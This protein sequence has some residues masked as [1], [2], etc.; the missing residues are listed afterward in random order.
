MAGV[1]ISRP[2]A[3]DWL[4]YPAPIIGREDEIIEIRM[5]L[6]DPACRLLTLVGTGGIGKTRLAI[7]IAAQTADK[8]VDGVYF[9]ALQPDD[10]VEFLM[11]AIAGVLGLTLS[12]GDIETQIIDHLSARK[13][14][15]VLDNLDHLIDGADVVISLLAGTSNLKLMVTSRQAL[16]LQ[17]EWRFPVSGLTYPEVIQDNYKTYSAIQLFADRARQGNPGF[18]LDENKD[19]VLLICQLTGGLPLALELAASWVQVLTCREIAGEIQR[20]VDFLATNQRDIPERHRSMQAVFDH[21]W[22]MLTEQERRVFKRL[23]IFRGGFQRQAAQAVA[24]ASL[25]TLSGL[26]NKSLLYHDDTNGRY[27]LQELLRQYAEE[28]LASSPDDL[29]S[30]R[31]SHAN[32]YADFLHQREADMIGSKQ[33]EATL[34]IAEEID[35]VRAAWAWMVESLSFEYIKRAA[36]TLSWYYEY[37]S[38]FRENARIFASA[39]HA[40]DATDPSPL[41]AS[42]LSDLLTWTGWAYIRLGEVDEAQRVLERSRELIE[43]YTLERSRGLASDPLAAL[44]LVAT[45]QGK[46]ED[47]EQ[48]GSQ[49]LTFALGSGNPGSLVLAYYVLTDVAIEQGQYKTANDLA[50]KAYAAAKEGSHRWFM[51][52]IHNQLG[53]TARALGDYETARQHFQA[54]HTIREAF[55]DPEGMAVAL[56]HLGQVAVLQGDFSGAAGLYQQGLNIYRE[57]GDRGGLITSLEGLGNVHCAQGNCHFAQDYFSEALQLA[58]DGQL[59]QFA[60]SVL[61][62]AGKLMIRFG[63]TK[64]G[65]DLLLAVAR[66]PASSKEVKMR[67]QQFL[68]EYTESIDVGALEAEEHADLSSLITTALVNLNMLAE[69][70]PAAPVPIADQ[71]L[72]DPLT[73]RELEVLALIANGL[74]NQQIADELIIARGTVKYYTSQI[75]SKLGVQS[76]TQAVAKARALKLL[77]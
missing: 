15:L 39:A 59:A 77:S 71:G 61:E 50:Q 3:G 6:A 30:T 44:S 22:E 5:L 33:Q 42:V 12:P 1:Q 53:R 29:E 73:A 75:Y 66:H 72:A 68:A 11:S 17:Q 58:A 47:A 10:D 19:D 18:S 37:Q 46:Y 9:V 69:H 56:N 48:L 54:S 40:I 43:T 7:E 41:Q 23:A 63:H 62:G 8:F 74:S 65:R 26:V 76:R 60:A 35:N 4:H 51:A 67:A 70:T 38:R 13:T 16:N 2:L 36:E 27:Y 14:L 49:A 64:P 20:S 31:D 24:G 25:L 32:Y 34:E 21:S 28:R 55:N 45:L 57:I 52:Y